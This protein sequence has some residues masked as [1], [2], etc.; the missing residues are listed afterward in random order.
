MRI[1]RM[2]IEDWAA[3]L[4]RERYSPASM[5]RKMVVLK[6]FCSYWVRRGELTESPFW[7]VH[8][9]YGRVVQLPRALTETEI[10]ELLA[11]AVREVQVADISRK[12]CKLARGSQSGLPSRE[13]RA[14]S[15]PRACRSTVRHRHARGRSINLERSGLHSVRVS[16]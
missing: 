12:R 16:F 9:S 15:E 8:L 5:R 7:R 2:L 13:Y 14:V 11:Q 1:A 4:R 10:K 3:H 6:V